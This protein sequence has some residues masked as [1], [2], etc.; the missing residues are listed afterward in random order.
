MELII[1]WILII[2]GSCLTVYAEVGKILTKTEKE[3][4]K[5]KRKKNRPRN[6]HYKIQHTIYLNHLKEN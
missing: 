5:Q 2:V 1:C 3:R 6:K 4:Q